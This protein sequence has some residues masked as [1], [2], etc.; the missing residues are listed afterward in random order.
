MS[1]ALALSQPLN[2]GTLSMPLKAR[3]IRNQQ[4]HALHRPYAGEHC[5]EALP[6]AD[7]GVRRNWQAINAQSDE[8][9]IRLLLGPV[10]RCG[11]GLR[12]KNDEAA[13]LWACCRMGCTI[14]IALKGHPLLLIGCEGLTNGLPCSGATSFGGDYVSILKFPNVGYL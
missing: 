10:I 2:L 14:C 5:A 7:G 4:L 11:V 9:V 1:G 12:T 6:R 8:F 13:S 3:R